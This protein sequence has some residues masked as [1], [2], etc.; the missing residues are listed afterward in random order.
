MRRPCEEPDESVWAKARG[1]DPALPLYPLVR[2]LLD[3]AAMALCLWDEYL[4][5][6][7][8]QAI[9]AGMGLEG[10][11][12]RAR[13]LVGLCGGLHDLGKLS[14]FQFCDARG[15]DGLSA[16]L[17]V[18]VGKIGVERLSHDVAGMEAIPAVLS[19]LGLAGEAVSDVVTCIAEVVGGH[20][21]RFTGL[22]TRRADSPAHQELLGGAS[23]ARQR[24]AHAAAVCGVLGEPP[25]PSRFRGCA[26]VLVTGLV[27]LADWLVSQEHYL[28]GR[29]RAL[30]S[31]L[32]EHFVVSCRDAGRLLVEAG[33]ARVE[34]DRKAFA[35]A[36]GVAGRPNELQR[37][38]MEDLPGA[39]SGPGI[40]L[41]TAAPGDGKT[42]AALEAER[43]MSSRCGARGFTFL[44]PTMATSDQMH[45]RVA[46]VLARQGGQGAG[47][48]L[49]HSMAW[50]SSA[51]ADDDLAVGSAVLVGDGQEQGVGASRHQAEMRPRRWLRGSKRPL[52]AQYTVGTI[53]QAL[54]SV[55]PVRHNALRLL[56]LSGKTFIVDEA[57][58][59]DP[60]MQVLLGR[61][62]NWLGAY[63]VPVILL[64]AT[65]P[66][67]VSDRLV[68]EYLGGAGAKPSVLKGRSFEA[69][70]PGWLYVDAAGRCSQIP[71]VRRDAQAVQRRMDLD[72]Q[73]E[74]VGPG[75]E[76]LTRIEAL[77][78]P[79]FEDGGCVLLVCNTV[80][81]AQ[82]TYLHLQQWMADH[83][84]SRGELELLHARFPGDVREAR[85]GRVTRG[86]GRG[87]PRPQRRIIVA[88]QVVEQSLD[89]DADLV[90][91]DLAPLALLL[92]RAGRC[93]RHEDHWARHSRPLG[94]RPAWAVES[95]PRLTVL[96]PVAG[97]GSVPRQW[98]TV[99]AE[100]LLLET[101][102]LLAER[103]GSPIAIPDD[104]QELVEA[105]HGDREDRFDWK[106]PDQSAA[107]SAYMGETLAQ[108][109]CGDMVVIPRARSVKS[110]G[111]LH[112]MAG[113][114]DEWR[115][116]TRL[117][118]DSV[119]LL[120]TYEQVG[121]VL[122]LDVKGEMPLPGPAPDGRMATADVRTVMQRTI[123]VRAEWIPVGDEAHLPPPAW[124]GHP[125][126]GDLAVVRQPVQ[127]GRPQP[128]IVRGKQVWLDEELGLVRQ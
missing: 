67:S 95:G 13:A 123:P 94:E 66:V 37:S 43:V 18:D 50:L 22:D 76:R 55:L 84:M 127:D 107:W 1:L 78:E 23:W 60:Y 40:L 51:Y 74:P 29:Q 61:L 73:V 9:A 5:R 59:Y 70:Y 68:K 72:V 2:H 63:G 64:S 33:L 49:T 26:G 92:Q 6:G 46:G 32:E 36:Y 80:A 111:A 100:F 8:R 115:A 4:S 93:W 28:L 47:L 62:L 97:T 39:V 112:R 104:V 89:L 53:D 114:E 17:A 109:Q 110:L 77:L 12:G 106:N 35:D 25:L 82:S 113:T 117:G 3:T 119:R 30:G 98:G 69:P 31:S 38:V 19:A 57:H 71:E 126:L 79:V 34:V 96:D 16:E 24:E 102:A 65:L 121:G 103:A 14:G 101:S 125:M 83:G 58:A 91:S 21:G 105:V 44:L 85:T 45:E 124:S 128:V 20:H 120:C 7:Q 75:R 48:T 27:I 54:M 52:L 15:R 11:L 56:A 122:T 99:Y 10:D 90:I 42:E 87:G 41:V 108:R 116:T 118:A 86:M 88:T 81:E